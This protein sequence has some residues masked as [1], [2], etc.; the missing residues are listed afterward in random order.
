MAEPKGLVPSIEQ[1]M[2]IGDPQQL[3]PTIENYC[4]LLETA[5]RQK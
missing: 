5:A 2:L 3:R 1:M 4:E